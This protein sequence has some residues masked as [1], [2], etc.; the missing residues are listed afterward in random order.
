M[1]SSDR[2][3]FGIFMAPFHPAGRKPDAGLGAR[4]RPDRASRP[5]RLRRGVDRRA[6]LGRHR[7]HCLPEIFIAAAA[8][9]TRHIKLGTGVSRRRLPQPVRGA[10]SERSCSI[11]SPAAG[12]CWDWA[13]AR[14]RPTRHDRPASR[15]RAQLLEENCR[16]V[17]KLLRSDEPVTAETKAGTWSTPGCTFAVLQPIVRLAVPA[18]ASPV[19]P[20]AGW[21]RT[22]SA[23]CPSAQPSGGLRSPRVALGRHGGARR[24][25]R[26]RS[27]T[28][29]N[30]DSSA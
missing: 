23:C 22:A 7:D 25:S 24:Q 30:G 8:E 17:M 5:P 1:S 16:G 28:A 11:T 19:G 20:E 3:R 15:P 18:V 9:R 14:C 10:P 26:T 6:P 4:P 12:S 2:L 21:P 13:R 27:P 29:T